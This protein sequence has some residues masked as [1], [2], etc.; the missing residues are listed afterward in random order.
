MLEAELPPAPEQ[1]RSSWRALLQT[2]AASLLACDFLTVDTGV[3]A[4]LD[5]MRRRV[6]M[7]HQFE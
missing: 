4:L 5:D 7:A 3:L 1:T 2:Q 6:V